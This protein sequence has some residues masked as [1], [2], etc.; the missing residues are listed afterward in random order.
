MHRALMMSFGAFVSAG[1]LLT[2]VAARAAAAVEREPRPNQFWWPDQLDLSPLRQNDP[3]SNPLG[4]DF[5]YAKAFATLD[6]NAV[7][8]D[9]KAVLTTS[10]EWWPSDYGNYGPFFV[11]MAWHGAGNYRMTD[12]RGGAGGAQQRFEPLN[13]WPDN[14][15]LDKARRLVWPVKQKYGAKLSW[16][17]LMVL[18]GNVAMEQMGFATFG[19]AGGRADDWEP[20]LVNWGPEKK[21]LA[22]ERYS[23]DRKLAKPLGA[24]QMGLI[25]VNP[26]GPNGVPDP[27]LAAKDI[28]ETFGRMAM[29]DEETV[30]LIAGGHAFGKAHGAHPAKCVGPEPAAAGVEAQGTGWANSCGTGVGKDAVTSGLEGAWSATPAQ[31]S[32]SYLANLLTGSRQRA[33]RVLCSG[34]PPRVPPPRW[35][36]TRTIR[37]S[38]TRRSCSPPTSR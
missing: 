9:L 38:V 22:D 8:A 11:R 33:P 27:L 35:C 31:W 6:L 20:E 28:R 5:N 7:K 19:F 14:G 21:F 17:D 25:Y 23:G 12:G 4:A 37:R 3:G 26:E 34:S 15:N 1:L 18:T 36:L 32:M 13:S 10:Q 2:P 29:N 16:G 24:V 30:A